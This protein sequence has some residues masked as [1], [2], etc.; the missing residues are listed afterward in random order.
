MVWPLWCD[1][2]VWSGSGLVWSGPVRSGPD[3]TK[4]VLNFTDL[5]LELLFFLI[6]VVIFGVIIINLTII[7][8]TCS[9]NY[10]IINENT[11]DNQVYF[12]IEAHQK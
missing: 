7:T 1:C 10:V 12:M 11:F 8:S 2:L 9:S 6:S 4:E 5:S 3:L